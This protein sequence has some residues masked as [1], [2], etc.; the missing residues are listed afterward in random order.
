MNIVY[1]TDRNFLPQTAA[2]LTSV[3]ENNQEVSSV[4]FYILGLGL[5]EEDVKLLSD[6]LRGYETDGR[7]RKLV[8]IG[9]GDLASWFD[10]DFDTTGWN[11]IVLAR[12]LMDRL[13]PDGLERVLYLDGDTIVRKDLSSLWETD[14]KGCALGA[15]IEPTCSHKRKEALGLAGKPYFNAG[16]LL[17][18]LGLWRR[19]GTGEEIIEYY[20]RNGGRLFANDQD[21][22]NGSQK[23][24]IHSLSVTYNYHNTY[25]IYRYRLLEKNCDYPVPSREELARIRRDPCIVHF[26]GE[27]RPWREGNTHRFRD[28]YLMYLEKTPFKGQSL[29]KGW[30]LYFLCWRVFNLVMKPFPMLRLEIINELIPLM[31]RLRKRS[32]DS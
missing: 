26:L 16:V 19:L 2:G 30:R 11:P 9:I 21:A 32:L 15:C 14:M 4:T 18:D 28:E 24:K 23:G 13:L 5:E 31:L 10:F 3:C 29:E 6:H 7:T 22:I 12:L 8:H 20:R 25:D 1:T 27:E 17:V